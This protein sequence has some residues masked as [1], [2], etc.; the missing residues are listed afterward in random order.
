MG[1]YG[2]DC[3]KWCQEHAHSISKDLKSCSILRQLQ[4][5]CLCVAEIPRHFLMNAAPD[6]GN[7]IFEVINLVARNGS[8]SLPLNIFEPFHGLLW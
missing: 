2:N 8:N 3:M 6:Q 7:R 5:R 1:I 4:G